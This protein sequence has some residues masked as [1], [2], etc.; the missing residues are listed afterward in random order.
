MGIDKE[1]LVSDLCADEGIIHFDNAGAS[2]MPRC[3][4]EAQIE[5]L[6]L[7]AAVGGY[8]AARKALGRL[9]LRQ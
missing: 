5:H 2:L 8:E 6:R 1:S 9:S 4:L 7:E 3:V